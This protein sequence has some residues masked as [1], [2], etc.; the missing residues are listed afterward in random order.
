MKLNQYKVDYTNEH[1][2]ISH[3]LVSAFTKEEAIEKVHEKYND[4]MILN[5]TKID[6]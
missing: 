5:I 4:Y 3:V 6:K 2:G 1:F